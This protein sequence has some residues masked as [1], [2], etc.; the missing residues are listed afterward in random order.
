MGRKNRL[1]KQMAAVFMSAAL[2]MG[3]IPQAGFVYAAEDAEYETVIEQEE[4][5]IEASEEDVIA[6]ES[7]SESDVDCHSE[8]RSDE[9]SSHLRL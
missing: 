7:C 2:I 6:S 1:G 5:T 9:E 4:A 3:M 8:E